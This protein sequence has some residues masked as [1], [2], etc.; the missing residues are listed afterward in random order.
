MGFAETTINDV[1]HS[2]PVDDPEFLASFDESMER[3]ALDALSHVMLNL[4]DM[5]RWA[6]DDSPLQRSTLTFPIY[7]ACVESFF[8]NARLAADFFWKMPKQDITA[9]S[10]VPDWAAPAAIAARMERLWLMTSKHIVHLSRER[11]PVT[12][13]DWR[14]EDLSLAALMGINRDAFKALELFSEAYE[15]HGGT[16]SDWLREIYDGTRPRTKAELA[17]GRSR[18]RKPPPVVIDWW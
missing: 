16:H 13:A 15:S 11:I 1:P 7:I 10:F 14:Q 17:R 4:T 8:T 5:P 2:Q 18:S 3:R 12:P 6:C 9:R